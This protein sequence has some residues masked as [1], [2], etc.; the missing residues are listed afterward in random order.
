MNKQVGFNLSST[1]ISCGIK[2][3]VGSKVEVFS[4]VSLPDLRKAK[5][6]RQQATNS[7]I[8]SWLYGSLFNESLLPLVAM[9]GVI[10]SRTSDDFGFV[11]FSPFM[12][13]CSFKAFD[14]GS[15]R[16][17]V[18]CMWRIADKY[19]LTEEWHNLWAS[20]A[21]NKTNCRSVA[22]RGVKFKH[23][24][25]CKYCFWAEVYDILELLARLLSTNSDL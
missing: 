3:H 13:S 24:Q 16:P 9:C 15:P 17:A 4:T 23:S 1:I 11:R 25:N 18:I 19:D 20:S 12:A 22:G 8:W 5:N 10:G 2:C 7:M 6:A 14:R 21:T